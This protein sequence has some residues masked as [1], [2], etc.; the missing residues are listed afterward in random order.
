M[1]QK[2]DQKEMII[3]E[4]AIEMIVKEG[5]DGLSMKKLAK[6]ASLSA[7]TIY[8]YFENR[9]DL[10][11][12]LYAQV[13]AVFEQEALK[14]FD[15]EMSFKEGLWIQ[16]MNRYAHIKKYPVHFH[17]S[18][19]FR[20]SPLINGQ[21][22]KETTP[23]RKNMQQFFNNAIKRKELL[24]L[25]PEIFWAMA[26]GPFYILLKFYLTKGNMAGK[27]FILNE[28]KLKLTFDLV[29]RSLTP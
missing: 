5:F 19:Q 13:E 25:D 20:N 9:E 21:T 11:N 17:F 7:S 10:L 27:P 15:P 29:L 28:E 8:I 2:D 3:R 6:E 12:K 16:W 23:F 4:K 14:N 22:N 24:N 1:R 18:E 26:Y